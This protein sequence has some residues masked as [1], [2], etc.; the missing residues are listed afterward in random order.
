MSSQSNP[1]E[2]TCSPNCEN[3]PLSNPICGRCKHS[4]FECK[5]RSCQCCDCMFHSDDPTFSYCEECLTRED[6]HAKG[7]RHWGTTCENYKCDGNHEIEC[8]FY[9]CQ[10]KDC[11]FVRGYSGIKN[12]MTNGRFQ[13]PKCNTKKM[14]HERTFL[15]C[16]DCFVNHR[17]ELFA[18]VSCYD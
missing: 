15:L 2:D 7:Y 9:R 13:C 17:S 11:F 12:E 1:A 18:I 14:V 8:Y 10:N 16:V 6:F 3:H 5:C 4:V